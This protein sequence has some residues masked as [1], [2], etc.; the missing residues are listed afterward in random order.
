MRAFIKK[1]GTYTIQLVGD[2][3]LPEPKIGDCIGRIVIDAGCS[4]VERYLVEL[5]DCLASYGAGWEPEAY[6][7]QNCGNTI[8]IDKRYWWF[9]EAYI[10]LES[11]HTLKT[12]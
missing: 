7:F 3:I 8:Q 1:Q 12:E 5:D 9:P 10:A 11:S 2:T 6:H 4:S